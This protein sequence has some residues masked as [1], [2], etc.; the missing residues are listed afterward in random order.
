MKDCRALL[1]RT[2]PPALHEVAERERRALTDFLQAN[3][4]DVMNNFD[5]AVVKLRRQALDRFAD[6]ALDPFQD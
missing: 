1:S 3:Y 6:A 5:P 4:H 2:E